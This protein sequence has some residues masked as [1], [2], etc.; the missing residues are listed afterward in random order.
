MNKS[1]LRKEMLSQRTALSPTK[2]DALSL[3]VCDHLSSWNPLKVAKT[4]ALYASING[5]VDPEGLAKEL[6]ERGS[7]L[8]YPRIQLMAGF[9]MIELVW[10]ASLSELTPGFRGIPEPTG[11]AVASPSE[12]DIFVVPAIAFDHH[13][14]RL[15]YGGGSYDNLLS[16]TAD[17]S[18][19][20]GLGYDF[21]VCEKLP[22]ESHDIPMDIVVT[23]SGILARR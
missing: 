3:K 23:E 21:Q 4:V 6:L 15:G 22:T 16:K 13:N 14:H 5:E 18:L 19:T 8:A 20:V 2:R 9:P 7:R 10:I 12:V 1:T 11:D 17:N